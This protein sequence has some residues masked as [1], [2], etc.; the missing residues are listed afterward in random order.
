MTPASLSNVLVWVFGLATGVAFLAWLAVVI[1]ERYITGNF[2]SL[3]GIGETPE[4]A[5]ESKAR[6]KAPGAADPGRKPK[7]PPVPGLPI[8]L[9]TVALLV[10]TVVIAT[11]KD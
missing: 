5:A 9:V 4:Q 1:G 2:D 11:L 7:S 3:V 8:L 6:R 10:V